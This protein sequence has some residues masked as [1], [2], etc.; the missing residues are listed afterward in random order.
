[1]GIATQ[2]AL[3]VGAAW[4]LGLVRECL[5]RGWHAIGTARS[6]QHDLA[7]EHR[8]K[9]A[10][11]TVDINQPGHVTAFRERVAGRRFW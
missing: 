1:M 2:T 5:G 11:E 7:D 6:A 4:G 9:V 8:G 3:V 10:I